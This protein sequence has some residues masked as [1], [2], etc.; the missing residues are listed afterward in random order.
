[1]NPL[2]PLYILYPAIGIT[3]LLYYLFSNST[4]TFLKYFQQA[5]QFYPL[6]LPSKS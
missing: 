3:F 1:M 4:P 6:F 2:I 5:P